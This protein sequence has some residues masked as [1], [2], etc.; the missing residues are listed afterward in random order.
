MRARESGMMG[1]CEW[2][3]QNFEGA[4]RGGGARTS[5]QI[6]KHAGSVL[7]LPDLQGGLECWALKTPNH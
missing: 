4:L 1:F 2:K 5:G 6:S 3:P 7:G